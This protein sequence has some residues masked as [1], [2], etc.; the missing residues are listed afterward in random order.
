MTTERPT[1]RVFYA[2]K[3]KTPQKAH[4]DRLEARVAE[5][6]AENDRLTRDLS[7]RTQELLEAL[8]ALERAGV[9]V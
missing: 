3:E 8:D 6:E 9:D 7:E 2:P 1:L 5:L 4:E